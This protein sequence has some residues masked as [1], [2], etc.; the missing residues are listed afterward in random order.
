MLQI[1]KGILKNKY[2]CTLTNVLWH[3]SLKFIIAILKNPED[4]TKVSLIFA[5]VNEEDILLKSEL[6]ALS[7]TNKDR[8]KLYYVLNNVSMMGNWWRKGKLLSTHSSSYLQSHQKFGKA[9]LDS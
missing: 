8:F 6:D 9:V 3:S 1:I 4:K 7:S 5:N 2:Q